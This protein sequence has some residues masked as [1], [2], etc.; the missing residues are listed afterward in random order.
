M[1]INAIGYCCGARMDVGGNLAPTLKKLRASANTG[2]LFTEAPLVGTME[3]CPSLY[4]TTTTTLTL[5][6]KP[7]DK[8]F[9]RLKEAEDFLEDLYSKDKRNYP[10]YPFLDLN[11]KIGKH[12]LLGHWPSIPLSHIPDRFQ[13][14]KEQFKDKHTLTILAKEQITTW[15]GMCEDNGFRVAASCKNPNTTNPLLLMHRPPDGV[16]WN[17][18]EITE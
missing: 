2:L 14:L 4:V 15:A 8:P 12:L 7:E 10:I 5:Q 16:E 11:Y 6:W 3:V 18:K 1:T 13:T 17:Y 9:M